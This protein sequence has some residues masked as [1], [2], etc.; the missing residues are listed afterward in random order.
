MQ[1]LFFLLFLYLFGQTIFPA[2]SRIPLDLFLRA[3]PLIA[4]STALSLRTVTVSLVLFAL[5][6]V[7][8]TLLL[9]RV[10]CGWICPLGAVLDFSEKIFRWRRTRTKKDTPDRFPRLRR[11]KY[12]LLIGL[13]TTAVF[14]AGFRAD[15]EMNLQTS[16]GLS[17]TY[18]FDP[19]ATITRSL[20]LGVIAPLQSLLIILH[21]DQALA[22]LAMTDFVL[23]HDTARSLLTGV[24]KAL[25]I[26]V[27]I[28]GARPHALLFYRFAPLALLIFAAIIAL[29]SLARRFWCRCICPLGALL[30]LLSRWAPVK[31]RVS[32]ACI[33]CGLCI[34]SCRTSAI[35]EDPRIYQVSECV[36]CHECI[37]IC[38]KGAISYAPALKNLKAEPPLNLSRRRLLH[39]AGIGI[40]SVLLLK[41]DWGAK[42]TESGNLKVSA[43]GLIRPPGALPEEEFVT[44]CVRCGECMKVCPTNGLQP[45]L[46]EGGLEAIGTPI[47]VPRIGPCVHGCVSCWRV[48][49]TAAIQPFTV[50]EKGWIGLGTAVIDHNTCIAWSQDKICSICDEVCPYDAIHQERPELPMGTRPLLDENKCVGCGL[51]E[52][53]CPT[54][55]EAAIRVYSFGDTRHLSEEERKERFLANILAL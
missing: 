50:E 37:S 46:G 30:G 35:T 12:Y 39:A 32:E 4:I 38:P 13:L 31:N 26:R 9:G 34:R 41:T 40:G 14:A 27:D 11:L 36:A 45:A 18:F 1:T 19:I 21:V 3:D 22:H 44:A 48:C 20:V 53:S 2:E 7:V 23:E 29:N 16:L 28:P 43:A 5:P 6:V 49:P 33:D 25:A 15:T 52:K 10:F 42:K 54:A 17:L 47:L 24:Q 51:C 8:L 55:P